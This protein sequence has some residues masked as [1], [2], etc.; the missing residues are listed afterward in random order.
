[1]FIIEREQKVRESAKGVKGRETGIQLNIIEIN[2]WK[3]HQYFMF[4]PHLVK[5]LQFTPPYRGVGSWF[6]NMPR[7]EG[8]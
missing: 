3:K 7:K 8:H 2:N 1:M 4:I 5:T 6:S